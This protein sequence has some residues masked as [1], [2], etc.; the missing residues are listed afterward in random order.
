MT[1]LAYRRGARHEGVG[2]SGE[3]LRLGDG[4]LAWRIG[5]WVLRRVG[6]GR[7]R[8]RRRLGWVAGWVRVTSG[9]WVMR[10]GILRVS[11][12]VVRVRRARV[13][14]RVAGRVLRVRAG[15]ARVL[16]RVA[17][18]VLRVRAGRAR[19]L[20]RVARGVVRLRRAGRARVLGR[21]ASRV[22]RLRRAGR[23]RVLGRVSS[24]ARVGGVTRRSLSRR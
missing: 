5:S 4:S 23:A 20:G 12:R 9:V 3:R 21:V 15:R 2:G 10:V 19:V 11:R 18:R 22:V 14:G 13:L 6:L 16:R 24:R 1:S 17:G 8:R 7:G